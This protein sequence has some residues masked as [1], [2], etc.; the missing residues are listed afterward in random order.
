MSSEEREEVG[1]V[2]SESSV[3]R[4]L[5][6][7]SPAPVTDGDGEVVS[8][9]PAPSELPSATSAAQTEWQGVVDYARSQGIQLPYQDDVVAIRALLDAYRR[10]QERNYY[11]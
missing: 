11:A 10:S 9:S 4:E 1:S 7:R 6:S 8:T 2:T 5:E 3:D